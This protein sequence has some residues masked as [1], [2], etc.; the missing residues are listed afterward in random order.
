MFK[1]ILDNVLDS[2]NLTYEEAENLMHKLLR[3]EL[4]TVQMAGILTALRAKGETPEEI[5]AFAKVM[6]EHGNRVFSDDHTVDTCGTGGDGSMSFN[7]STAA[8]F[9][10]A[11]AGIRVAKHGNRSVSSKCGSAD[12]LEA[13]GVNIELSP[14]R[15]Q[16]CLKETGMT[17]LFAPFFHP[18]MRNVQGARRELGVKTV[19]NILGPLANPA[20]AAGQ[21]LGVYSPALVPKIAKV[22]L[23]LGVKR[24][25]V[26]HGEG[27]MDEVTLGGSTKVAYLHDDKIDTFTITPEELGFKRVGSEV[28]TGGDAGVNAAIIRNIFAGE[29]GPKRDIVVLNAAFALVAGRA[30][31]NIGDGLHLAKRSIDSG[32]AADIL[33]DVIRF[34]NNYAPYTKV[35]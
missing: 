22:L 19:F 30:V 5:Y 21:V 28:F 23:K 16:D 11:G 9:V 2:K 8:A 7:I 1:D 3:G 18:S 31:D 27:G 29:K 25:F 33:L 13:L 20:G 17:F 12:V 15:A 10:A 4:S 14:E 32:R 24:A 26:V 6:R 34:S 35:S